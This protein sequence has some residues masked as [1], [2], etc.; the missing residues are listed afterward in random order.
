MFQHTKV[1]QLSPPR[2][3][4]TMSFSL[5][6]LHPLSVLFFSARLAVWVSACIV[7]H[8]SGRWV[9]MG[10]APSINKNFLLLEGFLPTFSVSFF[11]ERSFFGTYFACLEMIFECKRLVKLKCLLPFWSLHDISQRWLRFFV[12]DVYKFSRTHWGLHES[13]YAKYYSLG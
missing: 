7:I 12:I 10:S 3:L 8:H 11:F 2:S 1:F 5:S 13:R 4:G 9:C 6:L